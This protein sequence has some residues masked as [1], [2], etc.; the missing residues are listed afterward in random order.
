MHQFELSAHTGEWTISPASAPLLRAASS[1]PDSEDTAE[2]DQAEDGACMRGVR[3]AL[4]IEAVAAF[5]IYGVWHLW[6]IL[7]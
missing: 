6:H 4:A 2:P 1:F 5:F 3:Y 7:R